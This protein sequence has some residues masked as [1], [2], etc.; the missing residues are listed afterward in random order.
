MAYCT[1]AQ[2]KDKDLARQV[3]QASWVDSD[4]EDRI[5]EGDAVIDSIL[6]EIGYSPLPLSPVP[7]LIKRVS[8]LYAKYACLR[9]MHHHFSRSQAGGEGYEGFKKQ[10]DAIMQQLRD[11]ELA[12]VVGGVVLEPTV[13][14]SSMKVYSNTIE[15][16]RALTMDKP[17]NQ[18]IDGTAYADPSVTGDPE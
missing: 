5:A 10:F 15:V 14:S 18:S 3:T 4:V 2:A 6:A 16:P 17:E 13:E 7:E 1:A 11:K 8:I 12:L 9:D